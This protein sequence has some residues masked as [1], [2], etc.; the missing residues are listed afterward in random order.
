MIERP[1]QPTEGCNPEDDAIRRNAASRHNGLTHAPAR[2]VRYQQRPAAFG[3]FTTTLMPPNGN[4][5]GGAASADG[6]EPRQCKG[7]CK[8]SGARPS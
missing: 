7:N 2:L 3:S 6:R 8:Q 5:R 4:P 1:T